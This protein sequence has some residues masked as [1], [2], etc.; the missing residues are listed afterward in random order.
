M[1]LRLAS[2]LKASAEP[3]VELV[4]EVLD[5]A[6]N[7]QDSGKDNDALD[8]IAPTLTVTIDE[9]SRPSTRDKVNLRIT[10][11]ENI[12]S[13]TVTFNEVISY[14][15]KDEDTKVDPDGAKGTGAV[16]FVSSDEYTAVISA[17]SAVDGL[18]TVR[19]T[20]TDSTGGNLGATG[21]NDEQG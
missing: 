13:P 14:G 21:D 19:V 10:A 5:I 1:F 18:Y 20:A 2:D 12:G 7:E 16:K 8:R 11:D 17:A 4:G 3:K 9:G 15:T 6:G